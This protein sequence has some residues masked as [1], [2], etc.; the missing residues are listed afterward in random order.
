M[1]E[2]I[3]KEPQQKSK[4]IAQKDI[5]F[6]NSPIEAINKIIKKYLRFYKP[7]SIEGCRDGQVVFLGRAPARK[8]LNTTQALC[9]RGR[10]FAP[11]CHAGC[12]D[13]YFHLQQLRGRI[14]ALS[15]TRG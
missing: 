11:I 6:S 1:F 5:S 4:I 9:A 15:L 12:V 3:R 7:A 2:D 8:S 13:I 14:S 10:A